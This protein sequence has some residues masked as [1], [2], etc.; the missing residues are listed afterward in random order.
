M[1]TWKD[2]KGFEGH[3]QVS[4][5]GNVRNTRNNYVYH[6][7]AKNKRYYTVVL[8]YNGKRITKRVHRLVAET[9]IS[10]PNNLPQV[11]HKDLN[12][13]NNNVDNLE[14]CDASFNVRH[15]IKNG[16]SNLKG[17]K[18]Y[19]KN[20]CHNKYGFIYQYDLKMKFI[21]KYYDIQEAHKKT[22]V[23]KRNILQCINHQEGRKQAGGYIWI[24]ESEVV[25]NAL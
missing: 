7:Y 19:Q 6:M 21:A 5:L 14:W 20:K 13:Q 3:Y 23:C 2:I 9:F 24:K 16:A 22:K 18:E 25:N 12:K 10:N 1:E 8:Y 15:A 4:N 11:N 17:I